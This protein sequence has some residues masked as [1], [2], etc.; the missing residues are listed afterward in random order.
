MDNTLAKHIEVLD[1]ANHNGGKALPSL[2]EDKTA[3]DNLS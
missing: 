3:I 1:V 2:N